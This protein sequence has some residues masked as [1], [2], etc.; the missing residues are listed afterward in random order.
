[1]KIRNIDSN[2]DWIFGLG[3]NSYKS[4]NDAIELNLKTRLLEWKNDCFFNIDA[5]I[6]W[7]NLSKSQSILEVN[8][9]TIIAET[10]GVVS[11]DSFTTSVTDRTLIVNFTVTTIYS[12][13]SNIILDLYPNV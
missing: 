6:D 10:D 5:G 1:M 9:K 8:I 7:P 2:G 11:I 3:I 12:S 13:Q 4:N